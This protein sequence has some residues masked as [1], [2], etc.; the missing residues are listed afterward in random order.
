MPMPLL[1]LILGAL[2][3]IKKKLLFILI[4]IIQIVNFKIFSINNDKIIQ[5]LSIIK[6]NN[7]KII[8]QEKIELPDKPQKYFKT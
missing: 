7:G 6:D 3:M 5:N 2:K 1:F 8:E 4:I